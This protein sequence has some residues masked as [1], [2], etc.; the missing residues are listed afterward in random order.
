MGV[1]SDLGMTENDAQHFVSSLLH[2]YVLQIMGY[3]MYTVI[4]FVALYLTCTLRF[5]R[6]FQTIDSFPV[7]RGTEKAQIRSSLFITILWLLG[8]G[9]IAI[10]WATINDLFIRHTD[11][12]WESQLTVYVETFPLA[13]ANCLTSFL[14]VI[15]ADIVM[16]RRN[17]N[18]FRFRDG[19][20]LFIDLAMLGASWT[21]MDRAHRTN[22]ITWRWNGSVVFC[23]PQFLPSK[24]HCLVIFVI[25]TVH[26]FAPSA[27]KA[28]VFRSTREM[29]FL[30][31]TL[32]TNIFCTA[33]IIQR[34]V[35]VGGWAK[36]LK[37]YRGVM[38]IFVES[39][40]LY[41]TAYFTQIG[42]SV[43]ATY[44]SPTWDTRYFYVHSLC[45]VITVRPSSYHPKRH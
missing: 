18:S 44:F 39:A 12:N 6:G 13:M 34:L 2:S 22:N 19:S 40:I 3:G 17:D 43:Y 30:G 25:Q 1:L 15:S 33:A 42:M 35:S 29:I 14:L 7:S 32:F 26:H 41:T 38:E 10:R 21:T 27:R 28:L 8:G 23:A 37:T 4:Y 24:H 9:Q 16:V 20:S 31:M 36:A 11:G 45:N 5:H